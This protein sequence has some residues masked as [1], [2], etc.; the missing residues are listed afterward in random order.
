VH[1]TQPWLFRLRY[2]GVDV[3]LD[4]GRRVGRPGPTGS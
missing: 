2:D 1:N 3:L 4:R